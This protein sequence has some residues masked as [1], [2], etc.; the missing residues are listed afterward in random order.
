MK[1]PIAT[2]SLIIICSIANAV[3]LP[4]GGSRTTVATKPEKP[5]TLQ[6][7]KKALDPSLKQ[8]ITAIIGKPQPKVADI[9]NTNSFAVRNED[10]HIF[11]VDKNA[12]IGKGDMGSVYNAVNHS[13]PKAQI[14]MKESITKGSYNPTSVKQNPGEPKKDYNA[15]VQT[16]IN[17]AAIND[18][19]QA[20]AHVDKEYGFNKKMGLDA[21]KPVV[22]SN[23][24]N[25]SVYL[26]MKKVEGSPLHEALGKGTDHPSYVPSHTL[27]DNAKKA[28]NETNS[29]GISHND[30]HVGNVMVTKNGG[31]MIDYG[32][33]FNSYVCGILFLL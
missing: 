31:K 18:H 6:D 19:S 23:G 8:K 24:L 3:P 7:A 27:L 14:V 32:Y 9:K 16:A 13:D 33:D 26:P 4:A 11:T 17:G 1:L 20:K 2:V 29:K 15:R 10:N 12:R 30:A 21:G 25:N 22:V 28:I 5:P